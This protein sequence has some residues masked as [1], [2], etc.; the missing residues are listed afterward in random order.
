MKAVVH[1]RHGGPGHLR[2]SERPLP[3]P[4]TG[5][6]GVRVSACA[7][8]LSDWVC[9]TGSPFYVRM[10]GGMWRPKRAVLGSDIVGLLDKL[11][12]GANGFDLGN[13]V[14]GDVVMTRGGFA[15][16]AARPVTA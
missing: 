9:L 13:R 16:V 7:V 3:E 8:N 11:G 14:M 5:E 12:R 6:I 4:G 1:D 15:E 10:V 2:L